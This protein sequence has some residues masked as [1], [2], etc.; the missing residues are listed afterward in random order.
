MVVISPARVEA[1]MAHEIAHRLLRIASA[2]LRPTPKPCGAD[3]AM[4]IPPA[5]V[6]GF[7]QRL[8]Y[9]DCAKAYD[10]VHLK[11]SHRCHHVGR[12]CP[13]GTHSPC[14][15]TEG[16]DQVIPNGRGAPAIGNFG[17]EPRFRLDCH[18]R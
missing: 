16:A 13:M 15:Q 5:P 9:S 11:A 3:A 8:A 7:G 6:L 17:L 4:S 10:W 14:Q 18:S 2:R 1:S 12:S